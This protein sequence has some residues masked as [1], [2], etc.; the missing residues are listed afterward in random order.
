MQAP[1]EL[2]R[3]LIRR[4]SVTPDDAGCQA[5]I[6]ER[7]AR[8]GFHVE[9]LRFGSVDNLWAVAGDHGPITCFAGHTDV[10]PPGPIEDWTHD[11]FAAHVDE[12]GWLYGRGAADMKSSVAAMVCATERFRAAQPNHAGRLAFLLTS[13]EEGPAVDGTRAVLDWLGARGQRIDHCLIGEPSSDL[14]LA[15]TAKHGR[16]GSL[17]ARVR[18]RGTQGH[19]AYPHKADNALH[20]LLGLMADL[21]AHRWDDGDASFPPTSFQVSN[22]NAGT[23]AENVIPGV[24]DA[25]VN[26]RFSTLQSA[27][28]LRAV[29]EAYGEAHGIPPE[30]IDWHL[31]GAPFVTTEGRLIQATRAGVQACLGTTPALSTGGGTSD[32]R[33]IAPTG[34]EVIELGPCNQTIHQADERIPARDVAR[35]S[36]IYEAILARLLID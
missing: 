35:L 29:T 26:W 1:L 22:L 18:V 8:A 31:S 9:H 11:P 17:N 7:L 20:R 24:A 14:A 15:D 19:V 32:G 3:E 16:R 6:G 10:V 21:V 5:L 4:P 25:A 33:F 34:A 36:E 12:A 30:A 23:G 28:S 2:A 13:D 27:E